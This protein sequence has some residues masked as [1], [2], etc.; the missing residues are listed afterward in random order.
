[1][2]ICSYVTKLAGFDL[3]C[4]IEKRYWLFRMGFLLRIR[5][6]IALNSANWISINYVNKK[7]AIEITE[8]F[9]VLTVIQVKAK[10]KLERH[11][12][13]LISLLLNA[14]DCWHHWYTYKILY[15]MSQMA[16]TLNHNNVSVALIAVNYITSRQPTD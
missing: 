4:T 11:L 12:N 1:M 7:T 16:W 10:R 8:C 5:N 15:L 9:K 14:F 13:L 2:F 6:C 3:R